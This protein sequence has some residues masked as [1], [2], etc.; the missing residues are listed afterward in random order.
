VKQSRET[1]LDRIA[2][3]DAEA[4]VVYRLQSRGRCGSH[5]Q[6]LLEFSQL[7][8]AVQIHLARYFGIE[9][10]SIPFHF[11]YLNKGHQ[12]TGIDTAQC[13]A[14]LIVTIFQGNLN[15]F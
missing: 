4:A 9:C 14:V 7:E 11:S 13:P 15:V 10:H 2:V 5:F 8:L 3:S 12:A 6:A 1:R